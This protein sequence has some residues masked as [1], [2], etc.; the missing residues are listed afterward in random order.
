MHSSTQKAV[1]TLRY[2]SDYLK[3]FGTNV[4]DQTQRELSQALSLIE[5]AVDIK[6]DYV[7]IPESGDKK[8]IC[9]HFDGWV[10]GKDPYTYRGC[11]YYK[12]ESTTK[13][14]MPRDMFEERLKAAKPHKMAWEKQVVEDYV[15]SDLNE[16]HILDAVRLGARGGR[17]PASA[18]SLS[19][20]EILLRFSLL[21]DGNPLQAA[22]ALF[23]SNVQDYPQLLLRM[24]RFKGNDK[25]EFIDNQRIHGDF[26]DLLDGGIAFCFKHLNLHGKV[27][28]VRREESLDIPIEALR[29]ALINALCHRSFDSISGSVSLAIYD[30]RVEIENPGHFPIG[31]TPDTIKLPHDS[32]P[33]NPLI[34]ETL[35]KS[36]WLESWGSGVGRMIAECRKHGVPEPIYEVRPGGIA[37]IF[38]RQQETN[39]KNVEE[40][41]TNVEERRRNVE[42]VRKKEGLIITVLSKAPKTTINELVEKTGMS[43]RGIED[44]LKRWFPC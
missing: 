31:I 43:R 30:D 11:P 20:K 9:M 6:I 38:K 36:T 7:D 44:M 18:M 25:M 13:V 23:G 10:W 19:V 32:K 35:Y 3:D 24:A 21:K 4:T 8:V 26:F 1:A 33:F 5:P 34:A 16:A 17:M 39:H 12:V 29:E 27:V 28:G 41:Q 22:I 15:I 2:R 37:I 42:E 40:T 14:V